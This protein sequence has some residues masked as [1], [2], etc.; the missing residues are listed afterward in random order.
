MLKIATVFSG[1]GAI[2]HALKRMGIEHEIVF[3]SDNGEVDIFKKNIGTNFTEIKNELNRLKKIIKR[4]NIKVESDY[5][6][7]TDLDEHL[8]RINDKIVL[9]QNECNNTKLDINYVLSENEDK[10]S[11]K[12]IDKICK[13]YDSYINIE[14]VDKVL[15]LGL[16]EK[17][18]KK[19]FNKISTNTNINTKLILKEVKEVKTQLNMLDEK[20]ET[21]HI[22]SELRKIEDY[23]EKKKYVD[24]LYKGKEKS[25]FVRQSYFANY[26][27]TDEKFHWNV[28]FI[29]GDQ[30][31]NNVDLFVGGSPCQSF[32]M[33]GKQRGL[34]DTRGTL[35]YEYARLVKEI[36]PKVFIYENVKAVLSNDGGKTWDTM[37]QIF[38][39][40]GYQWK[41]MVLNSKDYGVA[42]NRE[43]IFVVGFRNDLELDKTFE[44]PTKV[45]LNKKM[46]DY[47]LDNVSG[48]YYLNKKGVAF[49]TD[50]KNLQKKWT[51]IDGDIQLCQKKN[52]QFNW[53]GDFVFVEKNINMEKTMHDLEKYF[54]S[55]KV[56]KYVLSS[57]TRNFYSKPKIDLDVARPLLTTMHK[58]HRAGVDN[59]VT[60]EGRIRKL[61]PRECL[62]LMGFCDSFKIVVSDTQIYQ[63]AG[64]SIV[65]DVLIHIMNKIIE[66]YP[67]II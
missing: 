63:Q 16:L 17:N 60:T 54:L 7:L 65:V 28:S 8:N 43:R 40:L 67:K 55:E 14:N 18:N 24:N 61:T 4:I 35:F 20:I 22:H 64:N 49:V 52:Q 2:E 12:E 11:K 58:M 1:I 37:S 39:D 27:I 42:Q 56:E 9:L 29:D 15:I 47:L 57:G 46:K 21:L 66:T 59:Y 45:E 36:Q 6:Y 25:N 32:S 26:D 44:E 31:T 62:R 30:Y 10:K 5:E 41:L 38:D 53:H 23:A 51:Q 48:K 34:G 33:V 13:E 3:A 50:D 19:L